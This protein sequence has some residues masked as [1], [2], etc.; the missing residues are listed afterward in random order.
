MFPSSEEKYR[1]FIRPGS[2][3]MRKA[4]NGLSSIVQN[5]IRLDPYDRALFGFSNRK[6]DL[7]KI[8]Y[9]DRNGFCLWQKRLEK[10]RFPW[11]QDAASVL[12][13]TAEQL[14]WL[15]NGIDF[16]RAHKTLAFSRV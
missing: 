1:I 5:E 6:R 10:D 2:T 8:L 3:D 4:I 12:E 13:I 7:I 15:L 14:N 11:P 9:W 16:R